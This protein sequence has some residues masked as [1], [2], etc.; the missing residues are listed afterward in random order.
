LLLARRVSDGSQSSGLEDALPRARVQR[1][2]VGPLSVGALHWLLRDRLGISFARQTLLRVREQSGGN[3]FFALELGRVLGT[4]LSPLDALPVPKTLEELVGARLAELPGSATKALAFVAALGTISE[5]LLQRLGIEAEVLQPAFTAHVIERIDA[6]IRF[7]HPL[8]AS[9]VYRDLGERRWQVHATIAQLAEDPLVRARHLA[10]SKAQPDAGVAAVLDDAARLAVERGAAA[11]SAELTERA[12]RLTPPDA[13][14]PRC[15]RTL[16]AARAHHVAGEWT[17]AEAL[18]SDLLA[19]TETGSWRAEALLLLAELRV[20]RV[21]ELLHQALREAA[22]PALQSMIHCRLAWATRFESGF[23]H[24]SAALELAEGL[25]DSQLRSNALAV[26]AILDWFAGN[27]PTP[28]D[29]AALTHQLPSSLGGERLVQEATVAI[30]NTHAV[31]ATRNQARVLFQRE[32]AEWR[33]RDEP[34]SARASWGLAWVEFWAGRW[35]LAAEHAAHAHE[36]SSQY[37]REVPQDHLPIAVI[38]VHR[39]QLVVARDHSERGLALADEQLLPGLPQHVAVLGLVA[40]WSGAP[41]VALDHFSEADRQ[42]ATFGWGEPSLRWWTP[43]HVELLLVL[44]RVDDAVD[45]L[46]QWA[47]DATRTSRER[48]LAH[49]TRCRGLVAAAGGEIQGA[50]ELLGRA[51]VEH[52]AVGDPFGEARGQLA[53]GTVRRR[54][55]QKSPARAATAAALEGFESLGAACWAD[56]ARAELGRIGGR[57]RAKGLTPAERRVASLVT[58]GR[59]NREIAT[60]LFLSERTVASHLTHIY[61]KLGVRSRTELTLQ[62][63]ASTP[64]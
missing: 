38:A 13:L 32:Y 26:Q 58:E 28:R 27:A 45:L 6:T 3:P 33:T 25:D 55:R 29:L 54:A 48:V 18:A 20:D 60:A 10:L 53:L 19:Q 35:E 42:A 15:R 9:V 61:A 34:R 36:I 50:L 40:L 24:A 52:A 64:V 47:A 56:R 63:H 37:G 41:S 8:L 49:V 12:I 30:V 57:T 31:S 11:A 43:D 16:A 44:G 23:D 51:I 39:G 1:V 46:D 14:E 4:D 62:F 2:D 21:A 17:R 7:T 22:S 5:S 59:T